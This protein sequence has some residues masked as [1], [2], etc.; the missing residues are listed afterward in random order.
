M[1]IWGGVPGAQPLEFGKISLEDTNDSHSEV[2]QNISEEVIPGGS[3]ATEDSEA[4][5]EDEGTLPGSK[6][7][8]SA[9]A[10]CVDD[11]RKKLEKQLSGKQKDGLMLTERKNR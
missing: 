9:T 5:N 8:K 7:R 10:R 2:S 4:I 3:N 6:K 11:K 1:R